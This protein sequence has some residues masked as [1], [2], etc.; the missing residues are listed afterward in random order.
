MEER[1]YGANDEYGQTDG[2]NQGTLLIDQ[3]P[4]FPIL[5]TLTKHPP[6]RAPDDDRKRQLEQQPFEQELVCCFFRRRRR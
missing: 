6:R 5:E 4:F 1:A 2:V 3:L